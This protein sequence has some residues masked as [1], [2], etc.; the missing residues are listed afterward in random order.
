MT[1]IPGHEGYWID[2]TGTLW[3][4]RRAFTFED[5]GAP[6]HALKARLSHKLDG[7][8]YSIHKLCEMTGLPNTVALDV[9]DT[10]V[11]EAITRGTFRRAEPYPAYVS[12]AGRVWVA[13]YSTG[14]WRQARV[15]TKLGQRMVKVGPAWK[16]GVA[17]LEA[18]AYPEG[19]VEVPAWED[20][21]DVPLD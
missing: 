5:D 2:D 12:P 14:R 19:R 6:R 21:S 15:F 20:D 18:L 10:V 1:P 16:V 9:I 13:D 8:S 3:S 4:D 11:Q 17:I 7:V